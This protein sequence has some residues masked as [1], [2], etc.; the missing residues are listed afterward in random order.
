[1]TIKKKATFINDPI[2]LTGDGTSMVEDQFRVASRRHF[3]L[4]EKNTFQFG[5]AIA[6]EIMIAGTSSH[7]VLEDAT[8]QKPSNIKFKFDNSLPTQPGQDTAEQ[9]FLGGHIDSTKPFFDFHFE[10]DLPIRKNLLEKVNGV[11]TVDF[12]DPEPHYNYLVPTYEKVLINTPSLTENILPSFYSIY[13]Q[14]VYEQQNVE[15]INSLGGNFT[16]PIVSEFVSTFN[17]D[18]ENLT[19]RYSDYFKQFAESVNSTLEQNGEEA[20]R[21]LGDAYDTYIF[22]DSSLP[23]LT[24]EASKAMAF[25][26]FNEIKFSTDSNTIFSNILKDLKIQTEL[27]KEVINNPATA[28][29]PSLLFGNTI[30]EVLP[31]SMKDTP[32]KSSNTYNSL[33]FPTWNIKQWIQSRIFTNDSAKGIVLGGPTATTTSEANQS[34]E[35]L[36]TKVLLSAKTNTFVKS[37]AR[38]FTEMFSG[39]KCYSETVFYKI[40]KF[41]VDN[42]NRPIT[43]F[44][45]PN[46]DS[47]KE[48]NFMDTQVVYCLLYTSEAADE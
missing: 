26:M 7:V 46:S 39:Q 48:C 34:I 27:I 17:R 20:L 30:A 29:S 31:S 2:L 40:E 4:G 42:P 22:D 23:T 43:T 45:I 6:P 3:I 18:G 33:S 28:N 5:T 14:A 38:T 25:P 12:I 16:T 21:T 19:N 32:P 15:A 8:A 41:S 13:S 10:C 37:N 9:V 24:T 47:L 36:L 35:Q 44:Y 11:G 1:M